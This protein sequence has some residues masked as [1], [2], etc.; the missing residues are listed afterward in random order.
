MNHFTPALRSRPPKSAALSK[1]SRGTLPTSRPRPVTIMPYVRIQQP[2]NQAPYARPKV[3]NLVYIPIRPH[4]NARGRAPIY[5]RRLAGSLGGHSRFRR[6][7]ARTRRRALVSLLPAAMHIPGLLRIGY[8]VY[9]LGILAS[10]ASARPLNALRVQHVVAA[11]RLLAHGGAPHWNLN[12]NER[13]SGS[14]ACSDAGAQWP[15]GCAT[16][17]SEGKS[18]HILTYLR[19]A[20][21]C[22]GSRM[23]SGA[24]G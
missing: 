13:P 23:T 8:F 6:R 22:R 2:P 24:V 16:G 3:N 19:C 20:V 12:W 5:Q 18:A 1:Y 7:P 9:V 10:S 21:L 17:D 15:W 14:A 4:S 11:R